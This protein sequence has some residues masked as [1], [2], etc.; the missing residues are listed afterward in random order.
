M[1][2]PTPARQAGGNFSGEGYVGCLGQPRRGGRDRGAAV[3]ECALVIPLLMAL[4]L[5]IIDYGLWFNDS[6]SVR[7]GVR[8]AARKA[9]VQTA[10]PGCASTGM[11]AVACGAKAMSVTSGGTASA[12]VFPAVAATGAQ[13]GT[14]TKGDLVVVCVAVKATSFTKFVPLPASGVIKSKTVMSI[15]NGTTPNPVSYTADTDPSGENWAWCNG[16]GGP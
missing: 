3:V 5:G 6:I 12:R 13:T 8:E 2:N 10:F 15:E 1:D 7:Q 4:V 14:W 16:L 9:A 11:A